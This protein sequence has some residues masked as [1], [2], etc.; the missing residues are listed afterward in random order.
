MGASTDRVNRPRLLRAIGVQ[1][2]LAMLITFTAVGI[3]QAPAS[4]HQAA[5]VQAAAPASVTDVANASTTASP[6]ASWTCNWTRSGNN[7]RSSCTVYSGYIRQWA[8]CSGWGEIDSPWVG[9]GSWILT[10]NCNSY[11]LTSWGY[12]TSG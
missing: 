10:T 3:S 7:V 6:L 12:D 8:Y 11:T 1:A 2:L 9:T 5:T 4:A